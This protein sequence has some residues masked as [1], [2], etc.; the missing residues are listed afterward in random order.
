MSKSHYVQL[1]ILRWKGNEPYWYTPRGFTPDIR[2]A[3]VFRTVKAAE[4]MAEQIGG[5]VVEGAITNAQASITEI[6]QTERRRLKTL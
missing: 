5:L 6:Q 2:E 1:R 3:L 4:T